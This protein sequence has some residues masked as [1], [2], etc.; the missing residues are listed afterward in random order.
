MPKYF[1]GLLRLNINHSIF[2]QSSLVK[3]MFF[4]TLVWNDI[5]DKNAQYG[6]DIVLAGLLRAFYFP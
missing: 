3:K 4:L 5:I 1:K 2:F 6:S